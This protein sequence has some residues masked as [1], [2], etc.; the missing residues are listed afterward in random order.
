MMASR[1]VGTQLPAAGLE[2]GT[3]SFEDKV[4]LLL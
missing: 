2:H 1:Q 3:E 4:S